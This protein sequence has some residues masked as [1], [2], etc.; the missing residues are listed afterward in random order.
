VI[1]Q[2]QK[3]NLTNWELVSVNP[4]EKNWTWKDLFCFWVNGLQTLIA[5]S[6]IASFYL[7]Y[8]LNS[9]VVLAGCLLATLLVYLF[10]NLIGQPSQKHGLPFPVILRMSMGVN[11]AK[12]IALLRG[13]VGLFMFGV[14]TFFISKSI[15]YIIRIAIHSYDA[16]FLNQDLFLSFFMGMDIIDGC[17]FIFTLII[18]YW[19]FSRGQ[20]KNRSFINFSALFVYF[21]LILFLIIIVSENF[22]EVSSNLKM[23]LNFTNFFAKENIMPIISIAGT[24]FAY[25]SIVILNFGDFSRY[26]KNQ[27]E[28][29]KGNF[30]LL[31]NLII[32]SFLAIILVLGS[33]IILAK[34]MI[35][36]N[37]LLTN[38]NDI[39]G[40]IDNKFLT[41]IVII[42][43]FFASA[44]TNLIANYIPS[45]NSLLNF[46]PKS[47][48]L[49]TTGLLII[50][51]GFFIGLLWLPIL[52]QI[53]L[54]SLVDTVSAFF[55]PL[56]GI[57]IA[58]Y[59][60]IKEKN[61]NNKDIFSLDSRGA[62]YFTGGW[63]IKG[64]YSLII[65]FIFSASTIWNPQ[66]DFLQSFSWIIGAVISWIT[67]Y[68]LASK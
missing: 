35:E 57:I 30:S 47:L 25:F 28:L 66:L 6:L 4:A 60:L 15:G 46:M 36:V 53:G 22:N 10:A 68:L 52:S 56:F 39:I 19:L 45:Q 18:Q 42:F 2:K 14:Q 12:Y 26:V 31:I 7:V 23:S 34:K 48:N 43:V 67:Y 41:T 61:I 55:G 1:Q 62:Y 27:S 40:K 5:F 16:N 50:F 3:S 21:G 8:D 37:Q 24:L 51:I 63:Q 64:I 20:Y 59:Y 54:L 58:D 33:D 65:G 11:G 38:P 9:G 49:N 29:K 44:S 32:F 13:L 17:S